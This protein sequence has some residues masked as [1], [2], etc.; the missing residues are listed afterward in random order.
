MLN[1]EFNHHQIITITI[2]RCV[3]QDKQLLAKHASIYDI[4]KTNKKLEMTNG[5]WGLQ[6]QAPI[7][8]IK[9]NS[10]TVVRR[11]GE[12]LKKCCSLTITSC[13]QATL[14]RVTGLLRVGVWGIYTVA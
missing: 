6:C 13:C 3:S 9:K 14:V 2:I 11:T 5:E 10:E 7:K 8:K 4:V 12:A 1:A